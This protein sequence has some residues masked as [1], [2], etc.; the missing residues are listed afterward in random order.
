MQELNLRTLLNILLQKLKWIVLFAAVLGVL[1]GGYVALFVDASYASVC[2]VY[3]MNL[4]SGQV[5][6]STGLSSSGLAASQL[7]VNEYVS[8]L[9]ANMII[10][11]VAADLRELGYEMT[12]R[13]IRASLTM[14]SKDE[15]ALLEIKATT[16]DPLKS[17]AICDAI[18]EIAPDKIKKVMLDLGTVSPVDYAHEGTRVSSGALRY[19][20]IGGVVGFVLAY[21]LFLL[22]F[23]LDNTVKN[24][25]E[26]KNRLNVTVLGAVPDLNPNRKKQKKGG[27]YYG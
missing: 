22:L 17:K 20:A 3:V 14:A 9:K 24:E 13:E 10:D 16:E 15:T 1:A 12:N 25:Q 5:N 23:L 21:A 19:A 7:M 8:L 4:T 18:M 2:S 27:Y 6:P 11:E 26:L